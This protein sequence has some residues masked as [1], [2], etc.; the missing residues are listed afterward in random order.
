MRQKAMNRGG[1]CDD[2][3]VCL[4]GFL[5]LKMKLYR[6]LQVIMG[7]MSDATALDNRAAKIDNQLFQCLQAERCLEYTGIR[8]VGE[9]IIA[10]SV[11]LREMLLN[12]LFGKTLCR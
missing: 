11:K 6:M 12:V 2:H 7:N 8:T 10:V 3:T 5:C 1:K 4:Y 9:Q